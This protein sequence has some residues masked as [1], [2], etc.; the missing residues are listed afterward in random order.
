M[1]DKYELTLNVTDNAGIVSEP[2][3]VIYTV[4]PDALLEPS[5]EI[6]ADTQA[7]E[8]QKITLE[9][10]ATAKGQRSIPEDNY[11]WLIPK[12]WEVIGNRNHKQL[13]VK[14]PKYTTKGIKGSF[15]VSVIDSVGAKSAQA[16]HS[17]EIMADEGLKPKV[18]LGSDRTVIE[19]QSITINAVAQAGD[20]RSISKYQFSG[21]AVAHLKG[22][23]QERVF[24]APSFLGGEDKYQ[25]QVIAIDN[26]GIQ[27][28]PASIHIIVTSDSNKD[29]IINSISDNKDGK[30]IEGDNITLIAHA[31]A[32]NGRSIPTNAYHWLIKNKAWKIDGASDKSELHLQAP[33][34]SGS[35]E[36]ELEV[37]LFVTDNTKQSSA[38]V[39]H[40]IIVMPDSKLKPEIIMVNPL[41]KVTEGDK[42]NVDNITVQAKGQR[43]IT[44]YK[45]VAS[46]GIQLNASNTLSPSFT[47]PAYQLNGNEYQL[48]LTVTDSTGQISTKILKYIVEANSALKPT[49]TIQ[50]N[51][52]VTENQEITLSADAQA[53][54]GRNIPE[55]NYHWIIPKGWEIVGDKE[56]KHITLKA[57][58]Y[59][60]LGQKGEIA[61]TVID[62][63]GISSDQTILTI[64]VNPD[65]TLK[66]TANAGGN[67]TIEEG[68][69]YQVLGSGKAKGNRYIKSYTWSGNGAKYLTSER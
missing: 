44:S 23:D 5:V 66:P 21:S 26:T 9:A 55:S 25:L 15:K 22:Q 1:Q 4:T 39:S 20:G 48:E 67:Q 50:G 7:T 18:S 47:A 58:A 17:I 63:S 45:W 32:G 64:S 28:E 6:I 33:A 16:D 19:G 42:V 24:T 59:S 57:P 11:H 69:S 8:G 65:D 40:T 37:S 29:P 62:S 36:D 2:S 35:S 52:E 41:R 27:S 31:Q 3:S 49:V 46:G 38:T 54:G 10:K 43:Q 30:V 60:G 14:V 61:L 51:K 34:Y 13:T 56:G 53:K 12:G 68:Q